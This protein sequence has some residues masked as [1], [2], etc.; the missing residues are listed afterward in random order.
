MEFDRKDLVSINSLYSTTRLVTCKKPVIKNT[1]DDKLDS[2]LFLS[3]EQETDG[4]LRKQGYFKGSHSELPLVS[5]ITIVYNGDNYLEQTIK[6]VIEQTYSNIEYI[7]IDGNSNDGTLDIIRKYGDSIDYWVSGNDNGISDAMN[8]GLSLSSGEYIVFIHSDDYLINSTC[9]EEVISQREGYDIIMCDILFGSDSKQ[10]V[11]RGF[12]FWMNFKTGVLHQGVI[13]KRSVFNRIGVFDN[14]FKLAMDYDFFLRAY[15]YGLSSKKI[16]IILSVMRDTGISS[17]QDWTSL[18]QRFNEE[19]K[20][21]YK[22]CY[23]S[24]MF[25]CYFLYWSFYPMYRLIKQVLKW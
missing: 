7:V 15:N 1:L 6:S 19:K 17:K 24:F 3:R 11:S 4:G 14:A 20:V 18:S 21:H 9:V 5:I 13:C 12:N 22:H 10:K 8:K 2:F 16:P 23:S 25:C